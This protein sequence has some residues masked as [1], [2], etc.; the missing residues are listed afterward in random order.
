MKST[1]KSLST[2]IVIFKQHFPDCD[3]RQ[4]LFASTRIVALPL[5]ISGSLPPCDGYN[6]IASRPQPVNPVI[7]MNGSIDLNILPQTNLRKAY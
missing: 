5:R 1:N 6:K 4:P 7:P 2:V 3:I